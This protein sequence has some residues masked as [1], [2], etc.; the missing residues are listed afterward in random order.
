MADPIVVELVVIKKLLVYA[1]LENGMSQEA[2]AAALGTNQSTV[3][4]MFGKGGVT[5]RAPR[6]R[7]NENAENAEAADA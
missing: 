1:L 2:V 5:K 7:K 3:S 6:P 4:R